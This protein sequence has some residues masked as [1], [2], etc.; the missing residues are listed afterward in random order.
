MM[1]YET[2]PIFSSQHTNLSLC[3]RAIH[4][5]LHRIG[6]A[7]RWREMDR[8]L[9][10]NNHRVC[11]TTHGIPFTVIL[12]IKPFVYTFCNWSE[13]SFECT[14]RMETTIREIHT[15]LSRTRTHKHTSRLYYANA[16]FDDKN[17]HQTFKWDFFHVVYCLRMNLIKYIYILHSQVHD[18]YLF[19][20]V[21]FH[22]LLIFY[23][24]HF[25]LALFVS[26]RTP[27][28]LSLSIRRIF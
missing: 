25:S 18:E 2:R 26:W 21:V 1:S 14:N 17:R 10:A 7:M 3:V 12:Y 24:F 9:F 22:R 16:M 15:A 11:H 5:A 4:R 19:F 27:R 13:Q 23:H 20:F 28:T 6:D 8:Q